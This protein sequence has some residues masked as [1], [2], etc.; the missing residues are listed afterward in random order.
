MNIH[1]I[2]VPVDF[3]AQSKQAVASARELAEKFSSSLIL[4]HVIQDLA[5]LLPEG[6]VGLPPVMPP[7]EQITEAVENH[8]K[9][10]IAEQNLQHLPVQVEIRQ[11]SPAAEIVAYAREKQMD[12]IVMGTHGRGG[13]AHL[14]LGSVAE[15]VLRHAP[16]P[17]LTIR[18]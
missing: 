16:C 1:K 10:L 2:L 4:L 11:G 6:M 7:I 8:M 12:L 3:S 14:L 15:R 5:V 9:L 13:L 18:S 17:V